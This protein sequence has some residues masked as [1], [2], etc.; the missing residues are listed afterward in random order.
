M[1]T[2]LNLAGNDTAVCHLIPTTVA[3]EHDLFIR[4]LLM[5]FMITAALNLAHF[6]KH[7]NFTYLGESAVYII[8]GLLVSA[9]WTSMSYD[10]GNTAIQLNSEFFSLVLLPPI[11]FEGGF[12]LQRKSFFSNIIPILSLA[13]FGAFFST[14]VSSAIMWG[15]SQLIM[16]NGWTVIESLVF[17]ALIS[18]TDPVT[19]LSLLPSTVDR[20]LYMLIFGES[21]LNDAVAI[22]LY[23]FFV[24]LQAEASVLGVLPFFISV[25]ASFG[26]FMGSFCVGVV[27]ALILPKSPNIYLL[28]E[29]LSLTGI[30]SIFFCGITMSHY[31]YSNLTELT[32]RTM[33]VTIRMISLMCE[34]F[35]FLYL[36]LG[37]LSF[38]TVYDPI[39][40]G[41]AII[42]ILVSRTHVFIICSLQRYLPDNRKS[43]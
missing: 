8:L 42:A 18:S 39:I 22:I 9:G 13:L 15:F 27:I 25:L 30:I 17:G 41:C 26:V 37:L 34:G 43:H 4:V 2:I 32:Q 20:R 23:R 24:G 29:V 33:K 14:F 12:N 11:I 7:Q 16:D 36:G 5:L 3:G 35:I 38:G 19:V 28:A 40:I 1:S 21:A 6:L 31:A 10:P